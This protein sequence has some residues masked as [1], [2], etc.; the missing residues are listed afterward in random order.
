MFAGLGF[1]PV[2]L[3]GGAAVS[4]VGGVGQ[5]GSRDAYTDGFGGGAD[6]EGGEF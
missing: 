4:E 2:L 1:Y 5:G 6:E 3:G